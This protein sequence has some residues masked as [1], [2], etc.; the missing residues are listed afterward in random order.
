MFTDMVGYTALGQ[1]NE[2]LSLALVEEQKKLIRPIIGRH[3]GKEIKSMGDAFLIEFPSTLDA[4][5][6]AYDIQRATREF[7]MTLPDEK[8]IHLRV[9]VHLGDVVESQGDISGD[10]VN[11]ASRIEPLAEDGGVCLTRQV[12]DQIGNKVELLFSSIGTRALKN[13]SLPIEVFKMVMPWENQPTPKEQYLEARRIAVL[14]FVNM[15]PDPLDEFFADGLT[16]EL[17]HRLSQIRELEVIARTSAMTY[18]GAKKNA[19]QI[20]RELR[21]GA[22]VEGSI[23]KVDDKIRVTVQLVNANTEG[24]LWSSIYDR[25]LKGILAVQ[26]DIA[27]RVAE[28]LRIQLLPEERKVIERRPT[29]STEAFT[30]YL[31]GRHYW[32]ER[33]KDAVME[34]IRYFELAIEKDPNYALAHVGLADSYVV[35]ADYEYA[36]PGDSLPKAKEF[37][38]RAVELDENLAEAHT[39]LALVLYEHGELEA[40]GREFR[41]AIDLNPS[42]ANAHQW[43]GDFLWSTKRDSEH[44]IAEKLKARDLDPLSPTANTHVGIGYY[45]TRQY[46]SALE[47]FRKTMERFPDF[48]NVRL[49]LAAVL[50]AKGRFEEA[51]AEIDRT[52]SLPSKDDVR[53]KMN[54]AVAYALW[55]KTAQAT[56]LIQELE[57][58]ARVSFVSPIQLA[59]VHAAVGESD[60]AFRWLDKACE[61]KY[62]TY[63][64]IDNPF[65][66]TI[67]ADRLG[68]DPRWSELLRKL[69][70]PS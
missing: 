14:P 67:L 11:V 8:R 6:C 46:D 45:A 58:M 47:E 62:A 38:E 36:R 34:A 56:D 61:E 39:S 59:L 2:S 55:G 7:N 42:Y 4:V 20:G 43:Y 10:A 13:V 29:V 26:T 21:A 60:E 3:N 40:A 32:N 49:W 65:Y 25:D 30:L 18:K 17:I 53:L 31:K 41:R 69:G 68:T 50:L 44:M 23:R 12:Y 66:H 37:A 19:A 9:G 64:L 48:F 22:L 24:H 16:E 51:M 28:A 1:R 70:L 15:S 57:S 5:R 63:D 52:A 27:E 54:R 35:L 33:A